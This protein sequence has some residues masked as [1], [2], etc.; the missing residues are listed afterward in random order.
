[1]QRVIVGV[2]SPHGFDDVGWTVVDRLKM[3]R[4]DDT[5]YLKVANPVDV[6]D[7]LGECDELILIDA[8]YDLT[9][10]AIQCWIWPN[11]MIEDGAY[12]GSHGFGVVQMLELASELQLLPKTVKMVGI[13]VQQGSISETWKRN[14]AT[15]IEAILEEVEAFYA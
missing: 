10:K 12:G 3:R 1:M 4:R 11:R 7:Y 2:G 6:L 14:Q 5:K 15:E 9:A 13:G 8:V